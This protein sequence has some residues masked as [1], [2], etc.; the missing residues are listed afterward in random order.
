MSNFDNNYEEDEDEYYED[1]EIESNDPEETASF[2]NY[3]DGGSEE[4]DEEIINLDEV[5][6]EFDNLTEEPRAWILSTEA[7]AEFGIKFAEYIKEVNPELWRRAR[8]YA[9]DYVEV[10][11]VEFN[12]GD[13]D[14][15]KDKPT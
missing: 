14:E 11:G 12:F 15:Q 1:D 5:E 4:E 2:T 3:P 6:V 13:E 7:V 8:D 10:D 9:L